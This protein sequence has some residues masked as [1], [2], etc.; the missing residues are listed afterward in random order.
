MH[1]RPRSIRWPGWG[2]LEA[3][4]AKIDRLA[5][6]AVEIPCSCRPDGKCVVTPKLFSSLELGFRRV[7][8]RG[9]E[10]SRWLL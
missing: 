5:R 3:Q 10:G 9:A 7:A 2:T 8:A 1:P 6:E 4:A